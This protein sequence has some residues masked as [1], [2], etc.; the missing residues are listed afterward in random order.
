MVNHLKHIFDLDYLEIG[1]DISLNLVLGHFSET[2]ANLVYRFG[3][4]T[5]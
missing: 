3:V 2:K 1:K 5:E 4:R